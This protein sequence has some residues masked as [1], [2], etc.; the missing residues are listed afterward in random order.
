ME[1]APLAPGWRN[2]RPADIGTKS[3][4]DASTYLSPGEYRTVLAEQRTLLAFVRTALAVTAVYGHNWIGAALGALVLA[5]GTWQFYFGTELFLT[6][7]TS[8]GVDT[9]KLLYRAGYHTAAVGVVMVSIAI[10]SIMYRSV[11]NSESGYDTLSNSSG[12][13]SFLPYVL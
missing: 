1:L 10:A 11:S 8:R 13:E 2:E 3:T 4:E 6:R 5:V 9:M 12:V 7:R